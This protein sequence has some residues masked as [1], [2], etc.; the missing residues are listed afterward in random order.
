MRAGHLLLLVLVLV[1]SCG[2][3]TERQQDVEGTR[4]G[5][6]F[7]LNETEALRSIFPPTLTQASAFRIMSQVYQGLV[8]FD[9]QDLTIKPCLAERWEVDEQATTFDFHLRAGVFFHDDAAFQDGQGRELTAEDVVRCF[10]L[11]CTKGPGDGT[12]WLFQDRVLGANEHYRSGAG[13][14]VPVEGIKLV[15]ERTVRITLAQASPG[16]LQ[17]VA[18]Q[19]CWIWPEELTK[20]Y[21]AVP[22]V[23]AIGT[24]P[25]RLKAFSPA[26]A[27]VLER[28]PDYWGRGASE[29]ALP[30][31]DAVRVTFDT[32]KDSEFQGLLAGRITALLE[33]PVDRI[34]DLSD[35]M[36]AATGQQ[37]FTV[38]SRPALASQFY[39][40]N[41]RKGPFADVKVRRAFALAIDRTFLVDS[42]LGG[43]AEPARHGLVPP[44]LA[45]YPYGLVPGIPFAPDSARALLAEAGYPG[46]AG[47]PSLQLQT[48]ADGFGYVR[49]A[50]AVQ[51]MLERELHIPISVTV[52][53]ADRHY[54]RVDGGS[55][56][57]W[58][59][60]WT[61]D[62]PDPENFL[63]LLYGKNAVL[64]S[65]LPATINK[66]RFNDKTFN[67]LFARATVTAERSERMRLLAEAEKAALQEMP[68]IPLYHEEA[69]YVV[70]PW[71]RGLRLNAIEYLD[72]SEV[73]YE[74]PTPA[75]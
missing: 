23:N 51:M 48:N 70:Q 25:F 57:F 64:D 56:L 9:P 34:R 27:M 10:T 19:G 66:T 54:D 41:A 67:D 71:V 13:P 22:Q 46:G 38:R 33:L 40:F 65:T 30:Y 49:V 50:E 20:E 60:G 43:L 53:P 26:Q 1:S 8:T 59:E 29:E 63:S 69:T 37:R 16:F 21:G 58:R 17:I 15:D 45:E 32:D 7:N 61:A 55:V 36:D 62:H 18:H 4:Y 35:S 68:I 14:E 73:W 12:F 5:G 2:T 31:L 42:V 39:G 75:P 3:S 6:V 52:M 74:R 44:G 11:I 28:N 47:F 72:L 24:G